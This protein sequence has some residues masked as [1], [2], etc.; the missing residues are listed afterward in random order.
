[1]HAC[2]ACSLVLF[3]FSVCFGFCLHHT[4]IVVL[5]CGP[6]GNG[7]IGMPYWDWLSPVVNGEVLPAIL[8]QPLED[9]SPQG[10]M[11]EFPKSFYPLAS[12]PEDLPEPP[13]TPY[14]RRRVFLSDTVRCF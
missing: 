4:I 11:T 10:L 8:Y 1:M 14:Y 5:H 3:S 7:Q 2:V 9:A 6:G 12:V 13:G